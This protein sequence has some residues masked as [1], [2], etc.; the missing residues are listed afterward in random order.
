[1]LCR[2]VSLRA[3]KLNQLSLLV[4][5]TQQDVKGN[6]LF[7]QVGL[8]ARAATARAA[9]AQKR[10][11]PSSSTR[12]L[13]ATVGWQRAGTR[14]SHLA[15]CVV[16]ARPAAQPRVA[17]H[18][19]STVTAAVIAVPHYLRV[20]RERPRD[21]S[22]C[23]SAGKECHGFKNDGVGREVAPAKNKARTKNSSG[24]QSQKSSSR[25]SVLFIFERRR[26]GAA[27]VRPN[28]RAER[29]PSL[30]RHRFMPAAASELRVP[31]LPDERRGLSGDN[32][33]S[34][35]V[36]AIAQRA[37]ATAGSARGAPVCS[38]G[39]WRR[40]QAGRR[41]IG[42]SCSCRCCPSKSAS[43]APPARAPTSRS[44]R[45]LRTTAARRG[46]MARFSREGKQNVHV[47]HGRCAA[48]AG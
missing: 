17:A 10:A 41:R 18:Q 35:R 30:R 21:G 44:S 23:C 36:R 40:G 42:R 8:P 19:A 6:G 48:L 34:C 14:L 22:W 37:M 7:N 39:S 25:V 4:M 28:A 13:H 20:T 2:L 15:R 32:A 3:L 45:S 43:R 26:S 31:A 24:Q 27:L 9:L 29:Y 5:D 1:M 11:V 16:S 47:F 46:C 33:K 38:R 12:S